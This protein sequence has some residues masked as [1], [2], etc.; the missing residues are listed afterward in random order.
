MRP[1]KPP[2]NSNGPWRRCAGCARERPRTADGTRGSPPPCSGSKRHER[3]DTTAELALISDAD[4]ELAAAEETAARQEQ[5]WSDQRADADRKLAAAALEGFT[6]ES[7]SGAA[8]VLDALPG[9]TADLNS[10]Q[11]Q[12]DTDAAGLDAEATALADATAELSNLHE[13]ASTLAQAHADASAATAAY[14]TSRASLEAAARRVLHRAAD[15]GKAQRAEAAALAQ[16]AETGG[17]I[18]ALA[19]TA[20]AAADTLQAAD[21]HLGHVRS[22][23]AAHT[24]GAGLSPGEPCLICARSLPS[25]YQPPAPA[26]PHTLRSAEAAAKKAAKAERDAAGSLTEAQSKAESAQHARA[27]LQT[28]AQDAHARYEQARQAAASITQTPGS[29]MPSATAGW[30]GDPA[31]DQ[32][33]DSACS[34]LA[35]D[36]AEDQDEIH[37]T[38]LAGLLKPSAGTEQELETAAGQ[39][40]DAAATAKTRADTEAQT[41]ELRAGHHKRDTAALQAD[42]ERHA[43][44]AAAC[45]RELASL[46]APVKAML[47]AELADITEGQIRQARQAVTRQQEQV[48]AL[49]GLRSEAADKAGEATGA[50]R[51]LE[52]Q[53]QEEVTNRLHSLA[54]YLDG[55]RGAVERAYSALSGGSTAAALPARPARVTVAEIKAHAAELAQAE[56]SVSASLERETATAA[57]QAEAQL[58]KLH[59]AATRLSAGQAGLP[60]IALPAGEALLDPSS[61][62]AV[63][64]AATT[65]RDDAARHRAASQAAQSQIQYAAELDTALDGGRSRRSAV[66]ILRG[67]LAEAKF[68]QYLT[69]RRTR[70]LLAVASDT[71]GTLS[72]GEFGF[73]ADFQVVSRRT[74]AARSPKTLSGGETFLASLALALGLVELH[75]RSG[76]RLGALF[77]D[78]GFASLDVDSLAGALT[79]LQAETGGDKLVAVISHLHAVAEAV[80]DVLW[81]ERGP[82]GS[83]LRWLTSDQRDALVRQEVTGGL[84][85]SI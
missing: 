49:A 3:K 18:P 71:F 85:S 11:E 82:D 2:T 52:H 28:A 33:L 14:R 15:D 65:A 21:N 39:A 83:A 6:V 81:V 36:T 60:A 50:R 7:L 59:D 68:L 30:P 84:L 53:R 58:K 76:A 56:Q 47:P 70:T 46:P 75:S 45:T 69:D 62:D 29:S 19:E 44:A 20:S 9:K 26:D 73:A 57:S 51:E 23:N 78:E 8:A 5:H 17:I 67:L 54:S 12:L 22:Q 48:S 41:L 43:R 55:L 72:G 34:Q 74:G 37:A 32:L 24:A 63:V 79:V 40:A 35:A 1:A 4:A 38:L 42:R 10:T 77:L 27:A 80:P 13:A 31:F 64:S 25:G 66:D 16:E 61:L